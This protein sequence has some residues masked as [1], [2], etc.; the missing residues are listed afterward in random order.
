MALTFK[1]SVELIS[2]TRRYVHELLN[3]M[4]SDPD[5]S[6]RIALTI[7]ELLENTLKYSTDG[8][9]RLDVA[10]DEDDGQRVVE[11]RSSNRASPAQLVELQSRIDALQD[12]ADPMALYVSM[13]L[14]SS[15]RNGSGL[16]LVRIRVEGEMQLECA[17]E[18]DEVTIKCSSPVE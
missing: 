9:A 17:I 2:S 15:R 7:H 13:M 5:A 4:L 1:P 18:G 8:E 3:S 10:V 11:I 14:E 12:L 6:S 16:G